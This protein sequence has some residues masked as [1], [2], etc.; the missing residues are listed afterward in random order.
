MN[1]EGR[2]PVLEG[3][4]SNPDFV[5]EVFVRDRVKKDEKMFEIIRLAKKHKIKTRF[6]KLEFLNRVSDTGKHQGVIA[7]RGELPTKSFKELIKNSND[8]LHLIY[9]RE[10]FN[11]FNIGSIIRTA[12]CTGANAV[13]LSPKTKITPQVV[14]ASM[15]ASEHVSIMHESLFNAIKICHDSGIKVVGIEVTGNRNYFEADLVGPVM[16]I[17]GGEDRS[18]S[19]EITSKCDFVIR[20]PLKGNVNSLN[21]S[22]A[23]SIVMYDKIRQEEAKA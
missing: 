15:G 13:V 10:S 17:I 4:R 3:L 7:V 16:F 11:E 23:A 12:E 18:L 5:R 22:I 1:I 8:H 2:N 21:M 6:V 19:E 9:I 14:R 20:I